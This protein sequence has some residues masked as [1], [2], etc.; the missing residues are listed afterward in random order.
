MHGDQDATAAPARTAYLPGLDGLRA[1]SVVAVLLYHA[2]MPWMPGGFLGVEVFFVISGYLITLL[3][4]QEFGRRHGIAA[5]SVLAAPRPAP[6]R[7]PVHAAG[8]RLHRRPRLLPRGR[9][10]ARRPGVGRPHLRHE[11]VPD[12]HRPVVLRHRR[13][14]DGVP[15]PLVAGDRGAVLPG[16]ARAAARCCSGSAA[17]RQW[18]SAIVVT[19]GAIASLVWMAVLFEPAMDP[20][21]VYYGT[22][23]RAAGLLLGAALA[24]VWKPTHQLAA[25]RRGQD[26]GPRPRRDGRRRRAHRLLRGDPGD[27]H[28]P[29]P[30]R[31]RRRLARLVRGDRGHRPPRHRAR[32]P[33]AR[34]AADDV[35]RQAVV[36]A[37][38]LALADLRVHPAGDR[39]AARAVP[40]AGAAPRPDGDRRRA[41]L[42]LRRGA[43]PQRRLRPLAAPARSP[44]RRPP[45]SRPDR[46]RLGGRAAPRRREHRQRHGVV[47]PRRADEPGRRPRRPRHQRPDRAGGRR[48]RG[49]RTDDHCAGDD[50]HDLRRRQHRHGARRLGAAR[51]RGRPRR[52]ARGGRVHRRL[53]RPAGAD[54]APVEQRPPGGQETRSARR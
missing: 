20:S 13:A 41:E 27:R 29:L 43:D 52:G 37:V 26:R 7:R 3:L 22:D 4:S 42:P 32:R 10:R 15:A 49:G 12:R 33:R 21:R 31:L 17:G 5:R 50:H 24:L 28:V 44:P 35:D 54:A 9:R 45:S 25:R 48:R 14:A 1:I 53:P 8:R 47:E 38:P 2:D 39:P 36:L 18:A 30:R 40:D 6:A 46:P 23:T 11:L 19:L 51:R 16:V 34:P